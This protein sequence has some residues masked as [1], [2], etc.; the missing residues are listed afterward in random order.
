MT[1]LILVTGFLGS[2]KT[3]L[4]KQLV[5]LF[6]NQTI[7]LIINEYG[8]EKV[9]STLL[10]PLQAQLREIIGG[11]MFCACRFDQFEQ[12]LRDM[13]DHQAPDILLVETSGLSDPTSIRKILSRPPWANRINYSGCLCLADA[14]RL[15]KVHT[16]ARVCRRQL[17]VADLIILNKCDLATNKE[18]ERSRQIIRS[19]RPGI[20]VIETTFAEIC[21]DIIEQL[22]TSH[23]VEIA[24]GIQIA[25]L[26][27]HRLTLQVSATADAGTLERWLTT[28]AEDT[29][30]MKGFVRLTDGEFLVDCVGAFVQVRPQAAPEDCVNRIAVLFG[31]GLPA[32][33]SVDDAIRLMP[34][35]AEVL[36]EE[37]D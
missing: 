2:G 34:G 14:V 3:T 33:N 30:R 17:S 23:E 27:L 37:T 5:R 35:L 36:A 28:F 18:K 15:Y 10:S 13:T 31:Y 19:Q 29:Y 25:D 1:H 4:I 11:S 8:R 21:P 12:A 20:P 7:G 9:D 26:N 6:P 22:R 16:T 32:R 24:G